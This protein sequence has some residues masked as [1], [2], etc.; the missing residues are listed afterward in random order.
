MADESRYSM[1]DS[2]ENEIQF[3]DEQKKCIDY[4][5]STA[6]I[7]K[8]TAG[9]GKSMMVIKR[10]I[11]YRKKFIE[12]GIDGKVCIMTYT[13]TL[14]Q[15]IRDVLQ[16]N[17]IAISSSWN[18]KSWNESDDDYDDCGSVDQYISVIHVDAYLT[19]L[20]RKLGT[21]PKM[22]T[23]YAG[24]GSNYGYGH[25]GYD[26]KYNRNAKA[27]VEDHTIDSERRIE[28][29]KAVLEGL[30]E[31]ED[32]PYFH[33]SPEFWADEIQW[34]YQNG[35][36]DDDDEPDYLVINREGRC[37]QYNMHMSRAGRRVA[38]RIFVGYNRALVK[39]NYL[40]WNREYA[41][42]LRNWDAK[43]PSEY[44]FDYLL[45]DEAQDLSLVKMK[46]LKQ[47]CKE[48]L[49]IAMDKNQSIYGHRWSFKR[50]LN[51][52]V[53]VKKL[54][55][56]FRGT[57]EID[58]FSADLK[59]IDDTLLDEEDVYSNEVSTRISNI[60]PKIVRC[61]DSASEI[62]FIVNEA[63]VLIREAPGSNVAILCLDYDHLYQFR[64]A[65]NKKGI[66]CQ[67]FRN[68]DFR[69][70]TGGVKLITIYSA[71]GLGFM[72]VI[73][74]YFTD[75]VYPK[76]VDNIISSLVEN[77][78]GES[79]ELDY[80]D[81]IAEEI[82]GS[83][84]LIYVAITRARANVILTYSSR[85]SRFINEFNP[86]HYKLINE[87]HE[88]IT[89]DRIHYRQHGTTSDA[90]ES[91]TESHPECIETF[92]QVTS[93]DQDP[94]LQVLHDAGVEF[95]DRRN[96]NGVLWVVDCPKTKEIVRKLERDGYRF[97]YTPKGS[98]STD[99]RP[100]YYYDG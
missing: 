92:L 74:P 86:V 21:L 20:C 68:N 66:P 35:I 26:C 40:E 28:I 9:S 14:A 30:S 23:G 67:F 85:P 53:H 39:N 54:S 41:L 78:D 27:V 8:G 76:S 4:D 96:K 71:K 62:D 34:M 7:I 93:D 95:I 77:Q 50:D 48:D 22:S 52:N 38:F 83:R 64:D 42:F 80:D 87:S 89:D 13:K 82:S 57:K 90:C 79:A 59:K 72:N 81:A 44:K 45:I 49:N 29:V 100:A 11:D 15:G 10:A 56:M 91:I 16:K 63:Q 69:P 43:I 5:S 70:L 1:V 84:R 2:Y 17:G 73:I 97:E 32:H 61:A 6:L 88:I 60:L 19:T 47:L 18:T 3:T 65:L 33:R 99:H 24:Y 37:K 75:G 46:I 55:V 31:K 36:V 51:M 25:R 98:R 12:S 94:I 58:E